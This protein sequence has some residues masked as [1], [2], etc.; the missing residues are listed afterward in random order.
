MELLVVVAIIGVLIALLLPAVQAAREAAR[1]MACSNHLHQLGIA[2]HAFAEAHKKLPP[3]DY[4]TPAATGGNTGYD[5]SIFYALAPFMEMGAVVDGG[6]T[7]LAGFQPEMLLCPSGYYSDPPIHP[8]YNS[9]ASNYVVSSG[10][11]VTYWKGAY[12]A[13]G[14]TTGPN[15]IEDSDYDQ[16][17]PWRGPIVARDRQSGLERVTDGTSNTVVYSERIIGR[18]SA[19]G[20]GKT[21]R[22]IDVYISMAW[23]S[24]FGA[25][26][27]PREDSTKPILPSV[28]W[29][30][31]GVGGDYI[32]PI[33]TG[34]AVSINSLQG[35]TWYNASWAV[36]FNTIMPPNAPSCA[37]MFHYMSGPTSNH[38]GGANVGFSDGSV[39][40]ISET[41]HC[42]DADR[43]AVLSGASPYGVWGALGTASA[44]EAVSIP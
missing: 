4:G 7:A 15:V 26:K 9:G 33:P 24:G 23:P 19:G 32:Q 37:S 27:N 18:V 25:V 42:G 2:T 16:L 10:D 30:F 3:H 40:F 29:A 8:S 38:L 35:H 6:S 1:R 17:M 44:G 12:T 43:A 34:S 39:H 22:M 5:R 36:V 31:T 20:G 13:A 21:I 41:I 28:C 11:V 14:V